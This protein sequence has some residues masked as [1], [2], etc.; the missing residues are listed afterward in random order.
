MKK[1][2]GPNG[3]TAKKKDLPAQNRKADEIYLRLQKNAP[4]PTRQWLHNLCINSLP[5]ATIIP[6]LQ[7]TQRG[8]T[9]TVGFQFSSFEIRVGCIFLAVE[10][11]E[12]IETEG[13]NIPSIAQGLPLLRR[14]DSAKP[15]P[16]GAQASARWRCGDLVRVL[17]RVLLQLQ[18]QLLPIPLFLPIF[19]NQP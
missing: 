9:I 12:A 10:C 18:L 19:K 2:A 1:A 11:A 14:V 6:R 3:P 4:F 15:N 16:E 5:N 8:E 17:V 7:T 13:R